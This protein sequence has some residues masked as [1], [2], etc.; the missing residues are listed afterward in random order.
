MTRF[1]ERG[2]KTWKIAGMDWIHASVNL[3]SLSSPKEQPVVLHLLPHD[4]CA[5]HIY[6][7]SVLT[8][9]FLRSAFFNLLYNLM[10]SVADT[11]GRCSD[12]AL[13][14]SPDH[15]RLTCLLTIRLNRDSTS[16]RSRWTDAFLTVQLSSYANYE[17]NLADSNLTRRTAVTIARL[18]KGLMGFVRWDASVLVIHLWHLIFL[19]EINQASR[20]KACFSS[21][22]IFS[23]CCCHIRLPLRDSL[24]FKLFHCKA[25][26][27][28][29]GV[30]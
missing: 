5:S 22:H 11:Q 29:F 28:K 2:S 6:V 20:L 10:D 13:G 3:E 9:H 8:S 30:L 27:G 17:Q 24:N 18:L 14:W 19:S 1:V 26:W 21:F 23:S 16:R 7:L 25:P 12:H 4:T 15:I